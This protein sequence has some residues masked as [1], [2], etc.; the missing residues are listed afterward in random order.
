MERLVDTRKTSPFQDGLHRQ[1]GPQ[2]AVP[3]AQWAVRVRTRKCQLPSP[4]HP[5]PAVPA[6][7]DS[8]IA[9]SDAQWRPLRHRLQGRK[10]C[11]ARLAV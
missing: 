2:G 3:T 11:G 5:W 6:D 7:A 1:Q 10:S 8:A 9:V 4:Q